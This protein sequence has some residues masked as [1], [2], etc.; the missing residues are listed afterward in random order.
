MSSKN[1]ETVLIINLIKAELPENLINYKAE[2]SG[3]FFNN[4]SETC[5]KT[6]LQKF[7]ELVDEIDSHTVAEDETGVECTY[8]IE[9]RVDVSCIATINCNGTTTLTKRLLFKTKE[10]DRIYNLFS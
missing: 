7:K 4:V 3:T 1:I 6:F 8:L 10:L 5:F 2:T 9:L